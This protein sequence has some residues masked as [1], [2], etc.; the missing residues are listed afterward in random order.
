MPQMMPINVVLP[1]P[2]G[3]SKREDFAALD[4][5]RDVLQGLEARRI[6][7]VEMGNGD[8]GLHARAICNRPRYIWLPSPF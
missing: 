1:A 3:P 8:H 7:L 5:E 2:F 4:V 6:G